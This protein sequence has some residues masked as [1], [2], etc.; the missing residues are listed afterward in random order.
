MEQGKSLNEQGL[1][2]KR[3]IEEIFAEIN[4][5][6]SDS[7]QDPKS[8]TEKFYCQNE[9]RKSTLHVQSESKQSIEFGHGQHFLGQISHREK[10]PACKSHDLERSQSESETDSKKDSETHSETDSKVEK[11]IKLRHKVSKPLS[12]F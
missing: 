6:C 11:E 10:C 2:L 7:N 3:H 12:D 1:R 8:V 4:E 5:S 9:R